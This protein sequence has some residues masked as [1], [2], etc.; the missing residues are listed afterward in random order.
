M[1]GR[2]ANAIKG[3]RRR[4]NES[5]F[6]PTP[7][8]RS[9]LGR[10]ERLVLLL[11]LLALAVILQILRAGPSNAL[12]S[13]WAEDGSIFFQAALS[14]GFLHTVLT[15]Y[16]GYLVLMPRL[17]GEV[18]G[19]VPLRDV[20]AV[21]AIVSASV[22]ALS[23]LVVWHASAGH[24]RNPYL[25]GTL[26]VAAI[27]TPVASL[28]AVTSGTYV[29]W[30]ML[31][32][33]FWL[34]LWRPATIWG[35]VLAALF[36]LATALSSPGVLYF[37]PVVALRALAARD[38]RDLVILSSYALGVAIQVPVVVLSTESSVSPAWSGDIVVSYLQRVVDGATLGEHLGGNA[39]A[40]FGW[41]FLIALL[42]C[43]IAGLAFAAWR[44]TAP[45]RYLAAIAVPTSVVM[46]FGSAYQRAVGEALVWPP[47]GSSGLGGR[48][49]IV[50]AMLLVSVALA[51]VDRSSRP[52]LGPKALSWLG[53]ATVA[54][55]LVAIVTSFDLR[56]SLARGTPSW[57]DALDNAASVCAAKRP[58][59]FRVPTSP[60]GFG[61]V[62][63]CDQIESAV[64]APRAR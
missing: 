12:G 17:I 28:E 16:A 11:G 34:L 15:P 62:I 43:L 55:V 33:A 32:A 56:N 37:A 7:A 19:L 41:P 3:L 38:R 13:I 9:T 63:P 31:F 23:G 42:A 35:A 40:S 5:L 4:L 61:V 36:I 52:R 10:G 59:E 60:P 47:G 21:L 2:Q 26:V 50:P 6:L 25:R 58:S 29:A 27:L 39:W 44:S 48:Y 54:V 46:F 24:I 8:S 57:D 20:P 51:L 49:A 22:I 64:A 30:Y 1:Q 53:M 14:G 18:G 45:T